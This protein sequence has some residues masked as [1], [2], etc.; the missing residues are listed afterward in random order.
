MNLIE[1]IQARCNELREVYLPEYDKIPT[2]VFAATMI[3]QSI[4]AAE[5]AIAGGDVAEMVYALKDLDEYKL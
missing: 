1:A 3:R 5:A 4:S 2:G